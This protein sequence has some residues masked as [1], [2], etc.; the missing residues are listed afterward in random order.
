MGVSGGRVKV[1]AA[2]EHCRHNGATLSEKHLC[3][4]W[5]TLGAT[6]PHPALSHTR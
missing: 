2:I 4:V 1:Q 6:V 5:Q 3:K